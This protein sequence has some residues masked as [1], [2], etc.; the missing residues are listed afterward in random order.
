MEEFRGDDSA[1]VSGPLDH[2]KLSMGSVSEGES[3]LAAEHKLR[4][5]LP[6]AIIQIRIDEWLVVSTCRE[7]VGDFRGIY[8]T[9]RY[10]G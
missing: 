10:L 4:H 5:P 3:A 6:G 7:Y 8:G 1:S 2:L 9:E